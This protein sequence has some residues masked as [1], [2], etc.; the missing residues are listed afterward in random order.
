MTKQIAR[1][2]QVQH[3]NVADPNQFDWLKVLRLSVQPYADQISLMTGRFQSLTLDLDHFTNPFAQARDLD[4]PID[5]FVVA[6]HLP[7]AVGFANQTVG[8]DKHERV[9]RFFQN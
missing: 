7:S 5:H 9:L 6:L 4:L 2:A 3:R 8:F 1:S